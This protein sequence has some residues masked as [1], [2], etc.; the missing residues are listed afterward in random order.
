MLLTIVPSTFNFTAQTLEGSFLVV[1]KTI[2][3]VDTH[4]AGHFLDPHV[5]H[6]FAP[7]F[8]PSICVVLVSSPQS[9]L[10]AQP[11]SRVFQIFAAQ[12]RRAGRLLILFLRRVC[13]LE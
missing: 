1:S 4:F 6:T 12:F 9:P 8:L 10:M 7:L 11:P 2:L 3:Q 13:G 5:L